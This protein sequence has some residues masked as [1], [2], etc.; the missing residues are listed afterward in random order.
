MCKDSCPHEALQPVVLGEQVPGLR[1]VSVADAGVGEEGGEDKWKQED[2][3]E[4]GVR[5]PIC[6]TWAHWIRA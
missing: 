2:E 5:P 1:T 4:E 6:E 3:E